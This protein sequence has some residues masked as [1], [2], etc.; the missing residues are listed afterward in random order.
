MKVK[1]IRDL[2]IE[3][4]S[5]KEKE[6]RKE[7]FNL[8]FQLAAGRVETPSRFTQVRREIARIKTI[9]KEKEAGPKAV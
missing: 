5:N 7:Y 1:E 9:M 2:T 6:L 8:K 4:L 3:E